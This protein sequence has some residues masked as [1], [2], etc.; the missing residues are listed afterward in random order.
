ASNPPYI[1]LGE[2]ADL[3]PEVRDHEPRLALDGGTD[4]LAFYRRIAAG[5]GPLLKPGGALL[6]EI[7]WTQED[8]VR[9]ILADR[10][11]LELGPTRRDGNKHPRVVTAR[12]R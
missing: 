6:L 12:K 10:P 4:G 9:A 8:A 3:S 5:V 1:A 11:E 2:F 7:G